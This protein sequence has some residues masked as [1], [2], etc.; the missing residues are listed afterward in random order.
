MESKL[1]C[2][3]GKE[4][5]LTNSAMANTVFILL[6]DLK[7]GYKSRLPFEVLLQNIGLAFSLVKSK[8]LLLLNLGI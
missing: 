8:L 3:D 7:G 4:G 1:N 2:Q 5:M 6:K